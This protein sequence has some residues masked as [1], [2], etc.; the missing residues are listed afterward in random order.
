MFPA[1]QAVSTLPGLPH[2]CQIMRHI[3]STE[4]AMLQ[5][6]I[7]ATMYLLYVAVSNTASP[8]LRGPPFAALPL[9][10]T[11]LQSWDGKGQ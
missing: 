1:R 11:R 10:S 8:A 4:G 7:P 2:S 6:C 5:C 9:Y 3:Q